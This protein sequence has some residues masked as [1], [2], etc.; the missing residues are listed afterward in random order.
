MAQSARAIVRGRPSSSARCHIQRLPTD[1][2]CKILERLDWQSVVALESTCRQYRSCTNVAGVLRDVY[3]RP[4]TT[5]ELQW[6]LQRAKGEQ[7]DGL[8]SQ[9]V[10]VIHSQLLDLCITVGLPL[11]QSMCTADCPCCDAGLL[12]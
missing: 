2:L 10:S 9:S 12:T 3:V 4:A 1:V 11:E 6:L 8:V 7:E 5:W